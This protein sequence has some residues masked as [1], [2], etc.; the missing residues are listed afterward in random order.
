[1]SVTLPVY[2]FSHGRPASNTTSPKLDAAG[3]DHVVLLHSQADERAYLDAGV[4]RPDRIVV[5]GRPHGLSYNRNAALDLMTEGEWAI[6]LVDD[7]L[8]ATELDDY[9]TR[10]RIPLPIGT[11]PTS[12][13]NRLWREKFKSPLP[14]KKF[15]DKR[16]PDNI[17]QAEERGA[18]LVGFANNHNHLFR[19]PPF[20]TWSLADGRAWCVRK[21]KIRF[22]ENVQ[23]IDDYT[24]TALNLQAF[25]KVYVDQWI[26]PEFSRYTSGGLGS[27]RN[28]L[29]RKMQDCAYV[30][31]TYPWFL[32]YAPKKGQEAGSHVRIKPI[33]RAG[34]RKH[35]S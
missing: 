14:L 5:T 25:G 10:K 4:V 24:F 27:I 20:T 31:K 6:F 29:E 30:T 17:K 2:V 15:I 7:F 35:G 16:C 23:T 28:R 21:T 11:P 1:M 12:E 33:N 32:E 13:E 26:L 18:A 8:S 34:P 3:V 22:D 9:D 19:K